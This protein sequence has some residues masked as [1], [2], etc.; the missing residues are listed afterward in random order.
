MKQHGWEYEV[1]SGADRVLLE[2]VRFLAAYRRPGIVPEADV[3]RAWQHVMDG[4][5]MAVAERR[6]AGDRPVCE[7]RPALL[8]LLWS[9]RLAT[10]LTRPLSGGSVLRRCA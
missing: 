10:D 3:E 9:G 2:N 5:Q 8:A 7:V 1:W 6:L 4:D